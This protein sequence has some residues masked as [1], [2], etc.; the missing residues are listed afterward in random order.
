LTILVS[1]A[2]W[3]GSAVA[4]YYVTGRIEG[5][6]CTSYIVF[7]T[8]SFV[9]IDAVKGDDGNLYTVT[10]RFSSVNEH[11]DG[12]CWI[13]TKS[14][15]GGLISWGANFLMAPE[16]LTKTVDGTYEPVDAEYITFPCDER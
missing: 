7:D 4:D 16:F 14:T 2:L 13:N 6:V 12:R 1:A 11:H 9:K 15:G 3:P 5:Q 8:C 10:N